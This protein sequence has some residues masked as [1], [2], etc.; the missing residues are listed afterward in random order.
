MSKFVLNIFHGKIKE[1]IENKL[2]DK[3]STEAY[4]TNL[5]QVKIEQALSRANEL[6]L[7]ASFQLYSETSRLKSKLSHFNLG[8]TSGDI[9]F[10]SNLTKNIFK[11][12]LESY[13]TDECRY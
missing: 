1:H 3:N 5:D 11:G 6:D 8:N 7:T 9:N 4:L 12:Y 13:I 10:L 2:L